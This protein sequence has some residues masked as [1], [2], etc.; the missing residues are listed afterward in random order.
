MTTLGRIR[1]T[2]LRGVWPARGIEVL[3]IVAG[4]TAGAIAMVAATPV[5]ADDVS[6]LRSEIRAL[7]KRLADMEKAKAKA[8]QTEREKA[9]AVASP[10]GPKKNPVLETPAALRTDNSGN[11][12]GFL[13]QPVMLYQDS[14]TSLHMYGIIEA[15]L[16]A[17]SNQPNANGN[18]KPAWAYGYQTAWFSGNRLGFDAD[19][20]LAG[21]G[22]FGLPDLKI[23]AKMETEFESPTGNMDTPGVLFNRDAWVGFQSKEL[24]KLTLGRQNTVT[25]D[26][27]QTWGDP[28]GT[29]YVTLREGGYSNVNNFKQI[30]YYSA[31]ST[32]TRNDSGIVWK[33]SFLDD[34]IVIGLDYSFGSQGV[35][36]SGN[37]GI[38]NSPLL[39]GGGGN[40]GNF[41]VGANEAV[42]IAYNNL[43]IG[44]GLLSVN[45]SYNRA[46]CGN[47][48]DNHCNAADP[49]AGNLINSNT[50][51]AFLVGG[52]YVWGDGYR[53]GAGYIYY[54]AQQHTST[55]DLGNRR[56][57]VWIVDGTIPVKPVSEK[58]DFYWGVWGAEGHNAALY[59][60]NNLVVLPFFISTANSTTTVNG[61]RVNAT[62]SLMY[63]WDKQTDFYVAYDFQ[64]G[65]GGWAHHLFN[66]QGNGD[67]AN[68]GSVSHGFGTGVRFKF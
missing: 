19:H 26:F 40:P 53:I 25:R 10:G 1:Q 54:D 21:G 52:T 61:S 7:S 5:L 17:Q 46:N 14:N 35:G 31:S 56:D 66:T 49:S 29:P 63:H 4:I 55:G 11:A 64:E 62:A 41:Q 59:G 68:M 34:H 32:L 45:A 20:A 30:I 24:G 43:P 9:A 51:Q 65:F 33:K 36:G 58:L 67:V 28:Y 16:S 6:E 42:S 18:N 13:Q 23:I 44:G 39:D 2:L 38:G 15:T 60:G 47:F 27:T 22:Q 57:N 48:G 12:L 8:E 37:G 50:N 3:P